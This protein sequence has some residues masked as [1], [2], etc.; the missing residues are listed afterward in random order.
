MAG[1]NRPIPSRGGAISEGVQARFA[2]SR[3]PGYARGVTK[4]ITNVVGFDDA[5]FEHSF[6][7]N[8]RIVG[9]V[10][11]RTRMDG[12]ISGNV[13]RDGR[14]STTTMI[15]LVRTSQF[16]EHVRAVLL[17]GIAVAGFNVVDVHA[18]HAGLGV[19]VVA[20]ARREPRWSR[21]KHALF[22]HT[23]GA[24]RKW[25][26]IDAAGKMDQIGDVFVQRVGIGIAETKALLQA[27]T[28]HGSLPEPLRLAHLV[29]GGVT[30]G[31][32]RGRA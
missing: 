8:V 12:V 20:V 10:C 30:T 25:A 24:A 11:S 14:N 6:R 16:K 22:A 2:G 23:T 31:K 21:I 19:P 13:R 15:E 29:A 9:I 17:Q 4:T 18:L 7:G 26:L 28:L 1:R 3:R 5:P 27:T 32:S